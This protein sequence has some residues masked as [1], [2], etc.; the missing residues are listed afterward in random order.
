MKVLSLDRGA[1]GVGKDGSPPSGRLTLVMVVVALV[2][3]SPVERRPRVAD[4]V[5]RH[6]S[7]VLELEKAI[8]AG[9]GWRL[10]GTPGESAEECAG[11]GGGE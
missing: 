10:S 3:L 8:F 4:V 5:P 6:E 11:S 2:V 7:L 1:L 9:H